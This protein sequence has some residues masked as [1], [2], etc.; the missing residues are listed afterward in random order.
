MYTGI[1]CGCH[2]ISTNYLNHL[3][4]KT[5]D[6]S[7][8]HFLSGSLSTGKH[9]LTTSFSAKSVDNLLSIE[10]LQCHVEHTGESSRNWRI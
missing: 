2:P 3:V 1:K 9:E 10:Q 8:L 5:S 4:D 6:K 7:R